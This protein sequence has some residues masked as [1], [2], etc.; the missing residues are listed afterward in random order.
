MTG[1]A[2]DA[3]GRKRSLTSLKDDLI[4]FQFAGITKGKQEKSILNYE[5]KV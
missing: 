3:S 2:P 4:K 1:A 5:K